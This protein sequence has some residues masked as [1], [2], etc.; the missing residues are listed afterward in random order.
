MTTISVIDDAYDPPVDTV[1]VGTQISWSWNSYNYSAHS[2]T[3][4]DG[5]TSAVQSS[6]G[7]NRTFSTAGTYTYYCMVHGT[8]MSGTI[9]VH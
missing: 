4:N 3:F 8:A 1:P 2:V 7:F 9:V 6:G 5:P